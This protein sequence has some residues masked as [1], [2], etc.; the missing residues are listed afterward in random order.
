MELQPSDVL[1]IAF[2]LWLAWEAINGGGGGGGSRGAG[3]CLPDLVPGWKSLRRKSS[4]SAADWPDLPRQP[5]WAA[6]P[7]RPAPRI[8]PVPGRP[9]HFLSRPAA[10]PS[11]I[12]STSCCAAA[13]TC[14]ISTSAWA[15]PATSSSIA[16]FTF[17]EPGGR[18]SV[19]RRQ[20]LPVHFLGL[21]VPESVRKAR[22]RPRACWPF[23]ANI[24]TRTDLD[25]I[26][27][28]QWL[29]EKRQPPRA[30]DRFWRQ[31]L[32][33]AINE[34]LDR[35]A[36]SHGFQVFRAG[37]PLE[38][39][40]LSDGRARGAAGAALSRAR[41]GRTLG[42][43]EI[44]PR[45]PVEQTRVEDGSVRALATAGGEL[46]GRFLHQ[47]ACPSNASRSLAA[48]AGDL[49]LAEFR[50]LADHRHSSVVRSARHR[51]AARHSAR[52]HHSVDVQQE[53]GPL[54]PAGGQ[55]SRSLVEMPSAKT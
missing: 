9:R 2:V 14:W 16:S 32:V 19:L 21:R 46:H 38:P 24:R 33:S 10:R 43:V 49:D 17:I 12:A 3:A 48:R 13:S 54:Y 11:T 18:A 1:F 53:R 25:R 5:L 41:P 23:A 50:A 40:V 27:M 52:P 22:G 7:P 30:I 29:E 47:R 36:A 26:T 6:R 35:M 8:P 42:N 39:G 20:L 4:S 15:S 31:V 34:D 51:S 55:R 37:F 28:Q 44:L 45:T